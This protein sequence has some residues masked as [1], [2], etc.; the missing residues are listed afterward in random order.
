MSNII[1]YITADVSISFLT[2]LLVYLKLLCG[3]K[4]QLVIIPR[5]QK[6][7]KVLET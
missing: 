6:E 2:N 4:K 7:H 3:G 5:D 1:I